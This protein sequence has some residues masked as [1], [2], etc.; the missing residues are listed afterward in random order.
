ML[1]SALAL[2]L[3]IVSMVSQ[4]GTLRRRRPRLARWMFAIASVAGVS[5]VWTLLLWWGR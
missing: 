3:T 1:W 5:L 4:G 2:V